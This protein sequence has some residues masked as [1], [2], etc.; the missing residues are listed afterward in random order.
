MSTARTARFPVVAGMFYPADP[1]E[2]AEEI[3]SLFEQ[4]E[5]RSVAG[6]IRGIIAPHAGYVYSGLTAACA[7]AMLRGEAYDTV[8]VVSPS[9]RE[10]FRGVSVYSGDL[11]VTPLGAVEVNTALRERLLDANATIYASEDGHRSEHALEVQLPFLQKALQSFKVLPVVAG[12]QA[13]EC[14]F[15]LGAALAA[16]VRGENALFV[17]STDLSH[18]HA[19]GTARHLDDVMIRDIEHFDYEQLMRDLESRRTEACGGGP[20]VAVLSALDRLGVKNIE[21]LH[22]A[23]SG[24]TTGDY[25]SVVGYVS[26]VVYESPAPDVPA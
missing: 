16:A 9:H 13:A 10:F 1:A 3:D 4:A 18:F 12:D 14:C 26:A 2:L 24:D 7:Y 21:V 15:D 23:T 8:V 11:Y 17:A 22:Y 25:S 20:T 5:R 6:R 19:S